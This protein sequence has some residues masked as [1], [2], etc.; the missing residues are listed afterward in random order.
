M[1]AIIIIKPMLGI[2]RVVFATC[3]ELQTE[4]R[5]SS[6]KPLKMGVRET[7]SRGFVETT[8]CDLTAGNGLHVLTN[9]ELFICRIPFTI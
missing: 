9:A 3:C 1:G 2:V 5:M 4:S 6:V 7:F 8:H